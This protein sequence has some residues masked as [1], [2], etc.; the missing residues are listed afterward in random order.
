MFVKI[1]SLVQRL[2]NRRVMFVAFLGEASVCGAASIPE[3]GE[4]VDVFATFSV[5]TFEGA[6]VLC[7][8]RLEA[9]P[10]LPEVLVYHELRVQIEH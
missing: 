5:A 4:I 10:H 8:Q 2:W 7:P 1:L 3:A 9:R 6:A